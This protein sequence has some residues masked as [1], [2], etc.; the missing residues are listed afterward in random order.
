MEERH[1]S[2]FLFTSES[3]LKSYSDSFESR[4][5]DRF[6]AFVKELFELG[7]SDEYRTMFHSDKIVIN[8]RNR[9]LLDYIEVSALIDRVEIISLNQEV[10]QRLIE[11]IKT[12]KGFETVHYDQANSRVTIPLPPLTMN[13]MLELA[14]AIVAKEKQIERNLFSV[15]AQT[16]QQIRKGIENEYID[17]IDAAKVSKE[18]DQIVEHYLHVGKLFSIAKREMVMGSFKPKTPED[19]ELY[20]QIGPARDVL[21][22]KTMEKPAPEPEPED[23]TMVE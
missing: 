22:G 6:V 14:D 18:I 20:E 16:G 15:K 19:A 17:N 12:D 23:M 5:R 3:E 1:L 9:R 21:L 8:K 11:I 13:Q 7:S 10:T 4:A 2:D